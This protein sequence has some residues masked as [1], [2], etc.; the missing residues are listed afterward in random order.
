MEK[1]EKIES[2]EFFKRTLKINSFSKEFIEKSL[3]YFHQLYKEMEVQEL[4]NLEEVLDYFARVGSFTCD[5]FQSEIN[6]KD[7]RYDINR[8]YAFDLNGIL[9]PVDYFQNIEKFEIQVLYVLY[10]EFFVTENL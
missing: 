4:K 10:F 7:L 3:M 5:A 9:N 8:L 1:M 6:L 2:M